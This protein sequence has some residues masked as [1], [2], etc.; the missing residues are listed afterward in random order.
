MT[1]ISEELRREVARLR[2][3]L[4]HTIRDRQEDRIRKVEEYAEIRMSV[5]SLE[6]R[7]KTL[8]EGL[9]RL[10]THSTWLLRLLIGAFL[11]AAANFTLEGGLLNVPH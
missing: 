3:D 6:G 1:D 8:E 11:V 2:D 5:V 10:M 7:L 4:E 9:A